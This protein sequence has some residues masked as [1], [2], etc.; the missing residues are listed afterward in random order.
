[1][2][3]H[4]LTRVSLYSVNREKTEPALFPNPYGRSTERRKSSSEGT[5]RPSKEVRYSD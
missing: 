3:M 2:Y 5:G 4:K 1:M